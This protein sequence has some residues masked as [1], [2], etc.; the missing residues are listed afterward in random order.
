VRLE[1]AGTASLFSGDTILT[2]ALAYSSVPTVIRDSK[3]IITMATRFAIFI[4][5]SRVA[6][7]HLTL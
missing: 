6:R 5:F 3:K 1:P 4:T 2:K 7:R